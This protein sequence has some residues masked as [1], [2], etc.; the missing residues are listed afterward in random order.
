MR[1][2]IGRLVIL[3]LS[4]FSVLVAQ[5]RAQPSAY[6]LLF[7][8]FRSLTVDSERIG[9]ADN[10]TF[11]R[12]A[13]TFFLKEGR[14][15]LTKPIG[16][17][18]CAALFIGKGYLSLTP[19]TPIEQNEL[20]LFAEK[21]SLQGEEFSSA[22]FVFGDHSMNEWESALRFTPR[23]M[24]SQVDQKLDR[25]LKTF[26][27]SKQSVLLYE[28]AKTFL[29]KEE[30]NFFAAFMET[31]NLKDVLFMVNPFVEEQVQFFEI[32]RSWI[33]PRVYGDLITQFRRPGEKMCSPEERANLRHGY[34][35]LSTTIN[36]TMTDPIKILNEYL[37][38]NVVTSIRVHAVDRPQHWIM[39]TM[40]QRL[41]VDS[42]RTSEGMPV[43]FFRG[44]EDEEM[45]IECNPPLRP[46]ETR[47]LVIYYHGDILKKADAR[48]QLLSS[49]SW[50]PQREGWSK[51]MFDVT[52][53][54]PSKYSLVAVGDLEA[55]SHEGDVSRTRWVTNRPVRGFTFNM[56]RFK[57][58]LLHQEGSP[59]INVLYTGA[60][61]AWISDELADDLLQATTFFEKIYGPL[62]TT[63]LHATE[64]PY[65]HGEAWPGL[66][67]FSGLT[68]LRGQ[69]SDEGT[70]IFRAHE[71]AHQWWGIG[72]DVRSYHDVWLGEAFAHYSGLMYLQAFQKNNKL[73]FE[74]LVRYRK[75]ILS[76]PT[77]KR[78]PI[79]LGYRTRDYSVQI[80][81][82][83]AWVMHMLR[84]M[85]M[86]L[87]TVNED[88]FNSIL[89]TFYRRYLNKV[90]STEDFQRVVEERTGMDMSWFFNQW[91]HGTDIPKYEFAHKIESAP[92][93]KYRV[94]CRVIT[95]NAA[96]GFQA[97]VVIRINFGQDRFA[98]VR[99]PIKERISEFD[100]PLLPLKPEQ[101]IFNDME[102]VL[103]EAKEV[104]W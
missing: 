91:I 3:F 68:F 47:T 19:T 53:Q 36:C 9:L 48:L 63:T 59:Y 104:R 32:S 18:V 38:F 79:S 21:K 58:K 90:A 76:R 28:V 67:H 1:L 70:L 15:Y 55:Q 7:Q 4:A 43:R 81:Q 65:F 27:R 74:E 94:Q 72:V 33:Q 75:N 5:K 88:V 52:F 69:I 86:D 66:I 35:V 102:S 82:K 50:Y 17:R 101:I 8:Q 83:G 24:H 93:G 103:C 87:K 71:A 92:D 62:T 100:L 95:S 54:Y 80:Y 99:V 22:F 2:W 96:E 23:P 97:F 25:G 12:D 78:R 42:I 40:H 49:S 41:R 98:R 34:R 37:D 73:F 30:N 85:F 64:T 29:E 10:Y 14:L 44:E 26:Y 89:S 61:D 60:A 6:E 20:L 45:W 16:D 31:E 56:G 46:D 77:D 57:Q 39:F 11:Q 13:A 51:T 84:T